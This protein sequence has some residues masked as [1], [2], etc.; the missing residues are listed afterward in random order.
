MLQARVLH[1]VQECAVLFSRLQKGRHKDPQEGLRKSR[2][3]VHEDGGCED[4]E[5][6]CAYQGGS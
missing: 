5:Q 4:G 2:A 3:G 6:E 1:L